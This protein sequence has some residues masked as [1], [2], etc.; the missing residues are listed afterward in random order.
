MNWLRLAQVQWR[1]LAK[2]IKGEQFLDHLNTYQPLGK[3][4]FCGFSFH[5]LFEPA[6]QQINSVALYGIFALLF[7]AFF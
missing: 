7:S 5:R 1:A 6:Y 3:G 2:T 4:L